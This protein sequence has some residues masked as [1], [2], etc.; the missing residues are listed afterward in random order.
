MK[1]IIQSIRRRKAVR[2]RRERVN[3]NRKV[4]ANMLG[5]I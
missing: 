2:L 4:I 1:K 3:A 5:R